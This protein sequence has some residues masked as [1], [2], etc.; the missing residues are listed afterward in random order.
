M[1]ALDASGKPVVNPSARRATWCHLG[2]IAC[3]LNKPNAR[4]VLMGL[5]FPINLKLFVAPQLSQSATNFFIL[6]LT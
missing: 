2:Q 6:F 3:L 1:D 4:H 5:H